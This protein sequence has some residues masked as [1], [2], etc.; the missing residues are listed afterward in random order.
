MSTSPPTDQSAGSGRH[1]DRR[2]FL[3]AGAVTA[4]AL[5]VPRSA[6]ATG[7]APVSRRL[8]V[9]P[10]PA[11]TSGVQVGD[12]SDRGAALWARAEG[13]GRMWVDLLDGRGSRHGRRVR[14]PAVSDAT[15]FTG[16]VTVDRLARG[17]RQRYR[18]WF[19]DSDGHRGPS[20]GG[21]FR[22]PGGQHDP[23]RFV[24][25]GDCAGQ[26]WG[27]NPDWGGMRGFEAMR[28]ES[29][30]FFVFS[31]DTVYADG[32]LA[33]QVVLADG[34]LWRNIVT[35]E[36]SKVAETLAEYRGQWR[37]NLLDGNV[38]RFNAEVPVIVQWDDH[39]VT[40]N[41][42]P[43]EILTDTGG[44]ARYTEKVVDTLAA[45]AAQAFHEYFPMTPRR[46]GPVH[47]VVSYGPLVDVFVLDMRTYR[48]P[49]SPGLEPSGPNTAILG[50][51]QLRWLQRELRRSRA[52]WKIVAVRHADRARRA[53]RRTVTSKRSPTAT[54]ASRSVA[55][56]RSRRCWPRSSRTASATSCG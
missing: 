43:G 24:W 35:P 38:R 40:N 46:P 15:D 26:G 25:T 53:R 29:P 36:K 32:P 11:L 30:D 19:E 49:N 47:R 41:W 13:P 56:S 4:G 2:R 5:A 44:D 20:E 3:L 45:R 16:Q 22:T 6:V 9:R 8:S 52:V 42:Y 21:S 10:G 48:G 50:A 55:S 18:V 1:V 12:V 54:P 28:Q 14:G 23:V 39:E 27:I 34:S 7:L 17:E 31:G 51:D 37:Y 33:A